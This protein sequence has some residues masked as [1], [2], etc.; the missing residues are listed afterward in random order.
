M[1]PSK[2]QQAI[3]T[4]IQNGDGCLII[5]AVAGA[6]KTTT[7]VEAYK[8]IPQTKQVIFVAFNRDI[9]TALKSRVANAVTMNSLGY[10]VLRRFLGSKY[11]LQVEA[12]KTMKVIKRVF[13]ENIPDEKEAWK[14][15][16]IYASGVKKL[17]GLAKA[18]GIV[19]RGV[20]GTGLML[21]TE[22]NWADLIEKYDVEFERERVVGV[23]RRRFD[24][25]VLRQHCMGD[26]VVV[27]PPHRRPRF[28]GERLRR[29]GEVVDGDLIG[30]GFR[31]GKASRCKA[32]EEQAE[33]SRNREVHA[34]GHAGHASLL[35]RAYKRRIDDR[36]RAGA[37]AVFHLSHAEHRA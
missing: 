24:L 11:S 13:S 1:T 15:F 25:A 2:Y 30:R 26:V 6:G 19:P 36:E 14:E 9:V 37:G 28:Y 7:I 17:V 22:Q 18:H 3:Y 16:S 33:Q 5:I 21:D 34:S 12:D 4:E 32:G 23:E 20:E 8:L 10:N 29:E 27:D 35:G 31:G